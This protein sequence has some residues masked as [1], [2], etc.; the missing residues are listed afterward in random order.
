MCSAS[1]NLLLILS[2]VYFQSVIAFFST[3]LTGSFSVFYFFVEILTEFIHF[4]LVSIFVTVSLN[5]LSGKLPISE[6]Y[7][8]FF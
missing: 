6:S 7:S 8:Y 3:V 1:S 5:F 4:L 2:S